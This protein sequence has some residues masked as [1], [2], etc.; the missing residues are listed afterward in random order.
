M[1]RDPSIHV[2]KSSFIK[3]FSELD[4]CGE[5]S[6]KEIRLLVDNL[7]LSLRNKSLTHRCINIS[8]D[9]L[10]N[11]SERL[12]N[13]KLNDASLF[14]KL[15]T[16]HRRKLKHRIVTP[17]GPGDRDWLQLKTI[18]KQALEFCKEFELSKKDGFN[19]YIE[20][21]LSKMKNFG[22]NKISNMNTSI[23]HTYEA[24]V[25]IEN[26]K[27]PDIT[28]EAYKVY[29]ALVVDKTSIPVTGYEDDK[30]TYAIFVDV[31]EEAIKFNIPVKTYITAQ[32]WGMGYREAIPHP[33]QLTG[34][35][36]TV[37]LTRYCYEHNISL[38]KKQ[39]KVDW[40]KI[41]THDTNNSK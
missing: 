16:I 10:L 40:K 8:N 14:S 19:A 22:I 3:V 18:T 27:N 15:L 1:Q 11:K 13:S 33:L 25:K 30:E 38:G 28:M 32:F 39:A 12:N 37:R 24:K 34:A 29:T 6:K 31:A 5:L 35:K 26:D 4:I 20:I 2:S 17:I 7:F 21:A 9:K 41:K 36:A 23:Y